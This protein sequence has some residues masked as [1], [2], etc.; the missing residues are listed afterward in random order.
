MS[1][2]LA[3]EITGAVCVNPLYVGPRSP[4]FRRA[5]REGFPILLESGG[6]QRRAAAAMGRMLKMERDAEWVVAPDA[7][8]EPERTLRLCAAYLRLTKAK[9]RVLGVVH[10]PWLLDRYAEMGLGGVAIPWDAPFDRAAMRD[11]ARELGLGW[12]HLLG[13]DFERGWDSTDVVPG[14]FRPRGPWVVLFP[15]VRWPSRKR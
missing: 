11:R 3:V 15:P 10:A 2:W 13:A 7:P 5:K 14:P 9:E 4:V 1:D 6:Y 12:V 8:G